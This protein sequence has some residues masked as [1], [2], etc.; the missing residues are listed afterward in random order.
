MD[1]KEYVG[2][3]FNGP[4]DLIY[5]VEVYD[6]RYGF[7]L[8]ELGNSRNRVNVSTEEVCEKYQYIL[9]PQTKPTI[10]SIKNTADAHSL[11]ERA[12]L[13]MNL[14]VSVSEMITL[15]RTDGYSDYDIFLTIHG[16]RLLLS[17]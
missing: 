11:L 15:F 3:L 14:N 1:W 7:R 17:K 16:A 2:E 9:A 10:R 12:M 13:N 5:E 4:D 8:S 6:P